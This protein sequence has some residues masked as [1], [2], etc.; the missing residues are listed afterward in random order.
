M[1]RL[2]RNVWIIIALVISGALSIGAW[3]YKIPYTNLEIDKSLTKKVIR[4]KARGS[5]IHYQE[6]KFWKKEKILKILADTSDFF[7][8]Q[9]K[10]FKKIYKVDADNFKLKFIEKENSTLLMCDVHNKFNKRWYDF[11]WFLNPLGLDFL[12]SHFDKSE[13][14]LSWKGVIDKIPTNIVLEFSF[15]ISNCHAHVWQIK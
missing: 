13:K 10:Q 4:I 14:I 9:I 6:M 15:H 5:V 12:N 11:H 1:K 7:S 3:N 2:N 8:Q